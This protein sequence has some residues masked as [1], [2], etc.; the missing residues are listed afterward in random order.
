MRAKL[1]TMPFAAGN[2]PPESPVPAPLATIHARHRTP[3][4]AVLTTAA[5]M[6]GL[7]LSGTFLWL[8][9]LSTLSRLVTYMATAGALPVLRRSPEAPEAKFRLPGGAAVA[10]AAIG[11]GLWLLSNSTLR[12][13][14]VALGFLKPEEF[15]RYV[16][17]NKM[18]APEA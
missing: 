5:I 9:T 1:M 3:S 12:E 2:A 7:T 6:L 4:L 14:A 17:P 16:Q 18:L 10:V 11:L 15:D 13:A 8:L